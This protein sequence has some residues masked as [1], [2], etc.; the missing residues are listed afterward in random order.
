MLLCYKKT[1][2]KIN[3]SF[4]LASVSKNSHCIPTMRTLSTTSAYKPALAGKLYQKQPEVPKLPVPTLEETLPK[5]LKTLKPLLSQ[6]EYE[7]SKNIVSEF[8]ASE[9]GQKLQTRLSQR[10]AEPGRPSWL[11]EWWN[12]LAYLGYRDPVVPFV[13]YFYAHKDD[14][15]LRSQTK[16]AA[17]IVHTALKFWTS[18][19]N[20]TLEPETIKNTPLCSN[21]YQYMFNTCRIP[22]KPSDYPV[23]FDPAL[24]PKITVARNGIFYTLPIIVDNKPLSI[25]EI[26]SQLN[27]IVAQADGLVAPKIGIFTGDYRDNWTDN[28]KLL[29]D[30][31]PE[32]KALLTEI[33]SSILLLCLDNTRPLTQNE[34]SRGCWHGDGFNRFFDKPCQFIVFENGKSGFL[35]EH[36]M[37]DGTPTARLNDYILKETLAD[38]FD[39]TSLQVRDNLLC[40]EPLIFKTNTP[41]IKA[42]N[43]AANRFNHEIKNQQLS[44]LTFYG[45][46]KKTISKQFGFSPD[47]F[48][49]M[50]IQ[51]GYYKLHG[52][53]VPTYEPAQTRKFARGR[54]EACRVVSTE[55]YAWVR[56]MEDSSIPVSK[57]VELLNNATT[58]HT[59]YV[60]EAANAKGVDRH[61]LGLKLSV[62]PDEEL[63]AL[64]KDPAYSNSSTWQISTSNISSEF[65]TSWGWSEVVPNGYGVAY[66]VNSDCI[67]FNITCLKNEYNLNAAALCQAIQDAAIDTRDAI[68]KN[69][70]NSAKS[71]L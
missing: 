64:F 48:A 29:L 2:V 45:Y 43:E 15:K 49:Q 52:K 26:E 18:V 11:E 40:P 38:D 20:E 33:E 67:Q 56:A 46:G 53:C 24:N 4:I 55:S 65:Y 25:A 30:A 63:P 3:P 31:S 17:A 61:L 59:K 51:L 42:L 47:A 32:N 69:G 13:S 28:R 66:S 70:A 14:K 9:I 22:R 62:K 23:Q 19:V 6:Q 7:S 10:A 16:R 57:K 54:T 34:H 71:K 41:V 60:S 1:P 36:S 39:T 68:V 50:L 35:G 21:S 37:M 12:D 58:A 8:Q 44:T 5:Y 27:H